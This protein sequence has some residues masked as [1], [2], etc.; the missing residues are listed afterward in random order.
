MV[1]SYSLSRENIARKA[2]EAHERKQGERLGAVV[3]D[4]DMTFV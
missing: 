2:V 3:K 1:E 4:Q